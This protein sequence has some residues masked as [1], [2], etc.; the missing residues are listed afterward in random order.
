MVYIYVL[1]LEQ[2][3][4]Y[5]GKTKNPSIRLDQ[6]FNFS[7]SQWT[8]KYKPIKILEII[9]NCD[10]FDE[11]KYTL[12]YMTIYG[13]D[14]VRGGSF[15]TINLN[16]TYIKTIKRMIHGSTDKCYICGKN[17][18]FAHECPTKQYACIPSFLLDNILSFC[19]NLVHTIINKLRN[20]SYNNL[21]NISNIPNI[22][23]ETN[24]NGHKYQRINDFICDSCNKEFDT[25]EELKKH[26]AIHKIN[27]NRNECTRCG[28]YG[29]VVDKCVAFTNTNG[30]YLDFI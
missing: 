5:V 12:K 30:E 14:N 25:C 13:I 1:E 20:R 18:H 19:S 9:P 29:H 15:C 22:P 24:L 11:D 23:N 6:H 21:H 2:N 10:D 27:K 4:Y 16:N 28:R 7:G 26:E 17:G 3:K 8:K